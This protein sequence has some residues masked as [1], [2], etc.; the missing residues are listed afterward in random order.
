MAFPGAVRVAGHMEVHEPSKCDGSEQKLA[1]LAA[2]AA[3]CSAIDGAAA[4]RE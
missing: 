3:P 2:E 1:L 4:R